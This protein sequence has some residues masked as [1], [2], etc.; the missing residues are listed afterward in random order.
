MR[1]LDYSFA[2]SEPPREARDLEEIKATTSRKAQDRPPK[3]ASKT[4]GQKV[5]PREATW[6]AVS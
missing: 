5:A 6:D 1:R 2:P 3:H 4:S